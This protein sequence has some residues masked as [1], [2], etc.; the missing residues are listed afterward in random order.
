MAIIDNRAASFFRVSD[1]SAVFST[2]RFTLEVM[3]KS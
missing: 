2:A 1:I 3:N